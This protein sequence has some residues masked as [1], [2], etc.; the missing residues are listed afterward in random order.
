MTVRTLATTAALVLLTG[1]TACKSGNKHSESLKQAD[2]IV[3]RIERVHVECELSK[4]RAHEALDWL[5]SIVIGDY[6]TDA[7]SAYNGFVEAV[8]A[9]EKQAESLR[10]AVEPM[11]RVAE[12]FFIN[13]ETDLSAFANPKMRRRSQVKLNEA[14]QRYQAIVTSVEPTQS[15]YDAFN[16]G[17]QDIVLFLSHDFNSASDLKREVRGLMRLVDELDQ[18]LDRTLMAAEAY[19]QS[20]ALPANVQVTIEDDGRDED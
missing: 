14:R 20:S 7:L 3:T 2:D 13:W 18:G 19:V 4:D 15:S 17:L 16:L 10:D 6:T 5:Q 11:E 12:P 1:L 9:S 8:E